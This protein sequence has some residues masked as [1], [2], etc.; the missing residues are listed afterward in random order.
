MGS[1]DLNTTAL[2]TPQ[3]FDMPKPHFETFTAGGSS[4]AFTVTK[5]IVTNSVIAYWDDVLQND[6]APS[7]FFTVSGKVVTFAAVPGAGVKVSI[8]YWSA[9]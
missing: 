7:P 9:T 8:Y 2:L 3:D 5:T 4:A 6:A 1:R